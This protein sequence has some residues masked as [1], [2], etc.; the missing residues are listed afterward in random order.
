MARN[1]E[2]EKQI[3]AYIK[4]RLSEEEAQEMWEEL[5]L[6]PEYIELL[7][8]EIAVQSIVAESEPSKQSS[9]DKRH[10]LIHTLQNSWKW[11]GAAATVALLVVAINFFSM[12][13][14]RTLQELSV[15]SINLSENLSSAP[16]LRSRG[17]QIPP[18]DSLL[19]LGFKAAVEGDL[20]KAVQLYDKIIREYP[21][22][23][24]A[25]KAYLNKGMIQ[26]NKAQFD[27]AIQSFKAVT[28]KSK[29]QS[30]IREKGFWYLGNAYINTDQP[31]KARK[32]IFEAYSMD[33]IYRTSARDLLK[34]L[35]EKL[36]KPQQEYDR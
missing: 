19:N 6:H 27:G 33:G 2:L 18:E 11:V 24:A 4:G 17:L 10:S 30:F 1:L 25:V 21:D 5:L 29:E 32:A 31:S 26:F 3:D 28:Q 13:S 35:D 22:R 9:G 16:V 23:P 8:T 12:D 34:R 14:T 20:D 7:N 36:G 15:N